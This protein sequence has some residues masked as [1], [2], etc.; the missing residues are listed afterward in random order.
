MLVVM[1]RRGAGERG[2]PRIY[3]DGD[4]AKQNGVNQLSTRLGA[5]QDTSLPFV[6][7]N[8]PELIELLSGG[9]VTQ[10][11]RLIKDQ[12]G[13]IELVTDASTGEIV[14]R[15]EH[16]EFGRVLSDSNPGLQPFG[17]AGGLYDAETG[18]VR[19]GARD[20][21]PSIGRWTSDDSI[22]FKDGVNQYAYVEGDPINHID[23]LGLALPWND[24]RKV[25]MCWWY[26]SRLNADIAN[27]VKEAQSRWDS[28]FDETLDQICDEYERTGR[29]H[30]SPGNDEQKCKEGS[31]YYQKFLGSCGSAAQGGRSGGK[32]IRI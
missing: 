6:G 11:L 3:A 32:K 9:V 13:T 31:E 24:W 25:I 20:Y 1:D 14:Q 26:T 27:C 22:R 7:D 19:F 17:F 18:L 12:V 23:P 4:G 2:P 28:S 15:L 8:V 21:D 5:N 10:R 29:Q 16:D 30:L